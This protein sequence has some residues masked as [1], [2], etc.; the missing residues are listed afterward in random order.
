MSSSGYG[1]PTT[2]N[3]IPNQGNYVQKP[4]KSISDQKISAIKE[5]LAR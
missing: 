2:H 1:T 3:T 4:V 5:V